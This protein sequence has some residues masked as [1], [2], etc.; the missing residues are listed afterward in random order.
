MQKLSRHPDYLALAVR[1]RQA[2]VVADGNTA[3][4]LR[5]EIAALIA[6]HANDGTTLNRGY[7]YRGEPEG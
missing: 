6:V 7:G 4:K 3:A 1:L 2:E 5:S